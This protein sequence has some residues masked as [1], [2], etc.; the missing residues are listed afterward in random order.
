MTVHQQSDGWV[1]S[2]FSNQHNCVEFRRVDG[3]V[4]V[5]NSKRPD[6]ATIRYTDSEWSAFIAGAKAG[7][8]D[9]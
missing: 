6:E 7:E 1:K 4:E 3:G 8:F 5:R 9:L 2:S